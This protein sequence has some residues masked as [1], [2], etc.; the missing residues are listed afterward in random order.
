MMIKFYIVNGRG[1]RISPLY[2]DLG[3]ARWTAANLGA[4]YRVKWTFSDK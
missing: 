2:D 3:L 4:G 1:D